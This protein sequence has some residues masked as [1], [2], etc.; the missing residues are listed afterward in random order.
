MNVKK[1]HQ[2]NKSYGSNQTEEEAKACSLDKLYTE[3]DAL[4]T[5]MANFGFKHHYEMNPHHPEY[6]PGGE[7]EDMN[8]VE[9]IVDGLACIFERNENHTDVHSW[10]KMHYADRFKGRNKELAQNIIEALKNYI[11]D[12]DYKALET[13]RRS[14]FSIIGESIPWSHVMMTGCCNHKTGHD[15]DNHVPACDFASCFSMK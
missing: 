6:F 1:W 8:L 11:T 7:M 12:A 3:T 10:L 5:A 13:F 2:L 9:A 4:T 15:R 14:I